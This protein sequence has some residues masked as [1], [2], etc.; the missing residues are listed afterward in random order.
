MLLTKLLG[1]MFHRSI[2]T[3]IAYKIDG[4]L[5]C[6]LYFGP[7]FSLTTKVYQKRK[8]TAR[9]KIMRLPSSEVPVYMLLFL[10]S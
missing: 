10:W 9:G 6:K 8:H 7:K 1:G 2:L 4:F 3:F 5:F